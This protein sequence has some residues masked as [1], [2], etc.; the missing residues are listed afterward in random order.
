MTNLLISNV[1]LSE[2]RYTIDEDGYANVSGNIA[3]A[4][5]HKLLAKVA[6]LAEVKFVGCTPEDKNVR[7]DCSHHYNAYNHYGRM[8]CNSYDPRRYYQY[9]QYYP[10]LN[11]PN[12]QYE[13]Y[14]P[15]LEMAAHSHPHPSAHAPP[16]AVDKQSDGKAV[17]NPVTNKPSNKKSNKFFTLMR[18][19]GVSIIKAFVY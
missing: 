19:I 1:L 12:S 13:Q 18:A 4:L 7:G 6:P 8:D 10:Y 2:I 15:Q 14:Y 5:L 9:Q 11:Y 16:P 3:P 17:E